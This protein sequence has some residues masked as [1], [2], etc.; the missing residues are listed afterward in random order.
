MERDVNN[1]NFHYLSESLEAE[2]S[3]R[4]H[5]MKTKISHE[6]K[7]TKKFTRMHHCSM[8]NK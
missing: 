2:E 3:K 5:R 7:N 8:V 6:K 1:I 4:A